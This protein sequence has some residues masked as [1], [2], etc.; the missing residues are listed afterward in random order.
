[1]GN[2][3]PGATIAPKGNLTSRLLGGATLLASGILASA[4]SV[5]YVPGQIELD[6]K[7]SSNPAALVST[8]T[9]L[10]PPSEHQRGVFDALFSKKLGK[11]INIDDSRQPGFLGLNM[12]QGLNEISKILPKKDYGNELAQ[13]K[14]FGQ[15]QDYINNL[16]K[17]VNPQ[18][19]PS[20]LHSSQPT[21]LAEF[22][23]KH[24]MNL[25]CLGIKR[26]TKDQG[27]QT[28]VT[29]QELVFVDMDYL[30]GRNST[31]IRIGINF[32]E[33]VATQGKSN[34]LNLLERKL[35]EH[36]Q[37]MK[38]QHA[39][40]AQPYEFG[41]APNQGACMFVLEQHPLQGM[42]TDL[43]SSLR[44]YTGR[45]GMT[46]NAISVGGFHETKL[47]DLL[48]KEKIKGLPALSGA[49][50]ESI[51]TNLEKSIQKA[52]GDG[53]NYFVFHYFLHGSPDGKIWT[54]NESINPQDFAEVISRP[55][56]PQKRPL[57]EQIDIFMWAASCY[58]GKQIQGIKTY[59]E[60]NRNIPVRN[61]RI[62]AEANDTSSWV[63]PA[64]KMS[65]VTSLPIMSDISGITDFYSAVFD[66]YQD[67]LINRG[68]RIEDKARSYLWKVRF[69]DLMSRSDSGES[70]DLLG[71]HFSNN[72]N[73]N[74]M[75]E[76]QFTQF[77]PQISENLDSQSLYARLE[78]LKDVTP[79]LRWKQYI[80]D[81]R[82]QQKS[83]VA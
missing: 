8:D 51:L 34:V 14:G 54:G 3:V 7:D 49:G 56:G 45:Y 71:F 41:F 6:N 66:E 22:N 42:E 11:Q 31:P 46:V 73:Y 20:L 28:I 40:W 12:Y 53:K 82:E 61:L 47:Q 38:T 57:C 64:E 81:L 78:E 43:I 39:I 33:A 5:D 68:V 76:H 62:I 27:W 69:I 48:E 35:D 36:K 23:K 13:T 70:Q 65:L 9:G 44:A 67:E 18:F 77:Q 19:L 10:R 30:T 52:I 29:G 59:F 17:E 74:K 63:L 55:Y 32:T 2:T 60:N 15:R 80:G 50:K 1:M 4:G 72:P 37:A 83:L 79:G 58:S 16:F 24:N 25:A 21:A 26:L 75:F